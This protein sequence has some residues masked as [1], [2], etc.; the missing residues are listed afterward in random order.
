[1]AKMD[2][3]LTTLYKKLIWAAHCKC[4][5]RAQN[6]HLILFLQVW[7]LDQWMYTFQTSWADSCMYWACGSEVTGAEG[8]AQHVAEG[9]LYNLGSFELVKF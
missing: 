6:M 1:M 4:W 7:K 3:G 9:K 8:H 2:R 5:T